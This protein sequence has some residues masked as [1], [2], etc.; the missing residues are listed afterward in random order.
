MVCMCAE[1]VVMWVSWYCRHD[2]TDCW[3]T[4]GDTPHPGRHRSTGLGGQGPP[5]HQR[6]PEKVLWQWVCGIRYG[7]WNTS[8]ATCAVNS[9]KLNSR[10]N[11]HVDRRVSMTMC[12]VSSAVS[13]GQQHHRRI[14]ISTNFVKRGTSNGVLDEEGSSLIDLCSFSSGRLADGPPRT[15]ILE[16]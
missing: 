14:G 16:C 5:T 6:G 12:G 4:P 3:W 13:D 2:W 10:V 9:L 15:R 7:E 1:Y 11:F 8:D